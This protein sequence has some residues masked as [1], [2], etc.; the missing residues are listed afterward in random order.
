MEIDERMRGGLAL[1]TTPYL[2][3]ARIPLA[4]AVDLAE[5]V[6]GVGGQAN[7]FGNEC[8]GHC[9]VWAGRAEER[10]RRWHLAY[11]RAITGVEHLQPTPLAIWF[12]YHPHLFG[13]RVET[14]QQGGLCLCMEVEIDY[15]PVHGFN[16]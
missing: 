14:V 5:A 3:M 12:S 15:Q 6:L 10:P 11:A 16:L 9:G 13:G 4:E 2:H 1:E 8:E 7:G